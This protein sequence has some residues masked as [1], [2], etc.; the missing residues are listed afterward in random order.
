MTIGMTMTVTARSFMSKTDLELIIPDWPAPA[1]VKALSTTRKGGI[2]TRPY[3]ALNLGSHV[4][5]DPKNVAHNRAILGQYLPAEPLWL[6]QVH[7]T[8]IVNVASTCPHAE[9]DA[10]IARMDRQICTIMTADC[11][12]VLL[13]DVNGTTVAAAHAGWRGLEAGII[14]STVKAMQISGTEIMAWLG[15]AIGPEAF[16]V[17]NEVRTAFIAHDSAATSAFRPST[18]PGKWLA[19]LYLLA[20]QRLAS[21]GVTQV[22]GADRCTFTEQETFFSY[23]RDGSTGRM[24]S[25]IWLE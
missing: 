12:P 16:E 3:A 19:N 20:Q 4:G 23:R 5:D 10:A 11:L 2:S 17:G 14:E 8:S 15:P 25:M 1:R 13:C 24:A 18:H 22:Y 9:A 7:G 21:C 6:T